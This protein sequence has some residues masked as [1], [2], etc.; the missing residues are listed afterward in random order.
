MVSEVTEIN[1][2][3]MYNKIKFKCKVIIIKY[4]KIN[5]GLFI[6]IN[7]QTNKQKE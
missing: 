1:I 3:T 6:N 5:S 2:L 4:Q 7:K